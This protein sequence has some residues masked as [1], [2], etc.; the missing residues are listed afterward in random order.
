MRYF[1]VTAKC[2]HVGKNNFYKGNIFLKA[3]N[4][5]EAASIARNCPRVKHDQKYA[6]INVDEICF[7][8]FEEGRSNNHKIHYFTCESVQ[9]QRMYISE[10]ENNI[11]VEDWVTNEPKKYAKKHSLRNTYNWD[12]EYESY[13]N[14]RYIDY[15]IA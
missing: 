8:D 10:I 9:E 7:E 15:Y 13:K 14:N 4:A 12:P 2:G 5:K 11:F 1:K 6:I 3:E